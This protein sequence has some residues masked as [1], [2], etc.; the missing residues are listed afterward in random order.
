MCAILISTTGSFV[1]VV[2]SMLEQ[3]SRRVKPSMNPASQRRHLL[4]FSAKEVEDPSDGIDQK[5]SYRWDG[6]LVLLIQ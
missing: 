5:N 4:E 2:F 1:V 6:P 3:D